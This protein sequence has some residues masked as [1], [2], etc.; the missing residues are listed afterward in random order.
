[1][2]LADVTE[3]LGRVTALAGG[4]HQALRAMLIADL[5]GA[6]TLVFGLWLL[7]LRGG[8]VILAVLIG[9]GAAVPAFFIWLG[10]G[11]FAQIEKLP[12]TMT[13]L[14]A[15]PERASIE[16]KEVL[17]TAASPKGIRSAIWEARGLLKELM[18]VLPIV[19]FVKSFRVMTLTST[20]A[21]V[22]AVPVVVALAL[23]TVIAGIYF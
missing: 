1:M 2:E 19:D 23:I 14:G 13:D 20:A 5:V 18:Q 10:S 16:A 15:L 17:A 22:A 3:K 12:E 6:L 8:W 9:I 11:L 21:A 7:G 4:V